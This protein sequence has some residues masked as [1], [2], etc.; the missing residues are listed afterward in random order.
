M[1]KVSTG[2][3][4][5]FLV[6]WLVSIVL[7][8]SVNAADRPEA[9]VSSCPDLAALISPTTVVITSDWRSEY[10][11]AE[12]FAA[13]RP[14]AGDQSEP[15]IDLDVISFRTA[16]LVQ[17]D[18]SG[19]RAFLPPD[20][21]TFIPEL[22]RQPF[23]TGGT[24]L[25]IVQAASPE[26]QV[27]L[28]T[29]LEQGGYEIRES[30]PRFAYLVSLD[31]A[32]LGVLQGRPEVFWLGLFQPAFR[33][34][35]ELDY[36]VAK[37]PAHELKFTVRLDPATYS[38]SG[39]VLG[40]VNLFGLSVVQ[41]GR[42]SQAWIAR[43]A[44]RAM[45]ARLLATL[46]SVLWVERY[47]EFRLNN[48]VARTSGNVTTGRGALAG[49]IMDVED[50]W[51]RGIRGE[52]QIASASDTG[53]DTGNIATA[54][55]MHWDFGRVGNVSNPMRV[56]KGYALGRTGDWS[57]NQASPM[58]GG[59]G[60]HTS[61]SIVGNGAR[62]GSSPGTNAFTGSH[63]GIAPKAQ[64]VFQSIMDSG[65]NLGGLPADLN[66]LFQSPYNDGAR[67]H[68]NS[69]GAAVS[70]AYT[71]DSSNTDKFAWNNKDMVI[72]F[73]AGNS[74]IDG[75]SWNGSSC[76]ATGAPIDGVI[77][78]GSIG[79]PGTAKNTIT[80]GA[81]EN[82]RPTASYEYPAGMC[83]NAT[84][85]GWFSCYG[86]APLAADHMANNASGLAAFSSRGPAADGRVKPDIVAPGTFILSTRS[87]VNQ[88][89]EQ[90]GEC[91]VASGEQ[92]YYV[93][94]GGTSMS[95]PLTAGAA[96]LVRQYYVDGWHANNGG[97]TNAA[98]VGAQGFNPS[99]ALVKATLIN[100]AWD[101]APGQYGTGATQEIPPGWDTGRDLPNNAEG[102]GR[103]DLEHS[104][105]PGSG[106]GD[107]SG[108]TLEVH[109]VAAGLVTGGL[110]SYTFQVVGNA[111]PLIATLVW[112]DPWAS[113]AAGTKLVNNLDLVVTGPNGTTK[114]TPNKV[115]DTAGTAD[116]LNNVEQV[117]VSSPAAGN[118]TL[119]VKG[120]NV[121]GNGTAGTTSQPYALVISGVG[122]AP[123]AA[124]TGIPASRCGTGTVGL[125]ASG[126]GTGQ[127]YRWYAA[128]IGG[129]PLQTGAAAYST[130]SISGTTTYYA[131]V[132]DTAAGC[133]SGRTAVTATVKA[134]PLTPVV[135][136]PAT[137]AP[138][139]SFTASVPL[140][141]GVSYDW[142]VTGGSVTA[143]TGTRQITITA[144]PSGT[145]SISI[146]ETDLTTLCVSGAGT[147]SVPTSS[148]AAFYTL[149]PCRVADTRNASGTFGGPALAAAST[150][151]YPIPLSGCS[152]PSDAK[153]VSAN[154]TVTGPTAAGSILVYPANLAS[155]PL[156]STL[157]FK[158]GET[159]ANNAVLMLATD[160]SGGVNVFNGSAGSTHFVID[161]NGYFR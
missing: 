143:G 153:A 121:P 114:Y 160:S 26:A 102:F 136:A 142:V 94:M 146:T 50:V 125:S 103:V 126:A 47:A 3:L 129:S 63:A 111:N 6:P 110:I 90:W 80:V 23:V 109:D 53:L 77:D 16:P 2:R 147:A 20:L 120:T 100:G 108:R 52:G 12:R 66:N 5:S 27:L 37:D 106:W 24:D 34:A 13:G 88:A 32:G 68:S 8:L 116:N 132:F 49:P 14:S 119:Q 72:T 145:V 138:G 51:A 17:V 96:T 4:P 56:I 137:V 29:F 33:F 22:V 31:P 95:N 151:L 82:Y 133:E 44:G 113:T 87:S 112:T 69:W 93:Y 149:S 161:V 10:P 131:S 101:M 65:G 67:V 156:A 79:A 123:P 115:D 107:V 139:H 15:L 18:G 71:T 11:F 99:S 134:Q 42:D 41:V 104:L 97:V 21:T 154:L 84:T 61:G 43:A 81:A 98:A 38:T 148:S 92:P 58:F 46:P 86:T 157:N 9:Q 158:A 55:S 159:R 83:S 70:G 74:G 141:S 40:E 54:D 39:E 122:C 62:S 127:A 117:K 30:I 78:T 59:H 85:W 128:P 152:I 28:R 105:F 140:V 150:R 118:W 60:T 73:S 130:P 144:G 135:T 57:D 36:I 124:P 89:F 7:A 19:N 45:D 1:R 48:D 155:P 35:S 76:A 25:F 64:F 91:G 75:A